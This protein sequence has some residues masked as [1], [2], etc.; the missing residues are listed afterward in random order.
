M[1]LHAVKD[2]INPVSDKPTSETVETETTDEPAAT[3]VN[4][5]HQSVEGQNFV[6]KIRRGKIE[7]VYHLYM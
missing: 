5:D 4:P 3:V 6:Q 1:F 7:Q 2:E